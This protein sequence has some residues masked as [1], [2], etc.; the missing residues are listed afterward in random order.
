MQLTDAA[1][2]FRFVLN[3][4]PGLPKAHFFLGNILAEQGKLDTAISHFRKALAVL[5]T[6]RRIQENFKKALSTQRMTD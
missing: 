4:Q 3:R 1:D 2:H 5:P 6:D